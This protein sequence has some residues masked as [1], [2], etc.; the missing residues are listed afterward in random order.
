MQTGEIK[1]ANSYCTYYQP[2][3]NQRENTNIILLINDNT[4]GLCNDEDMLST[5]AMKMLKTV[6]ITI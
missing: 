3:W 6:Y 4:M 5:K 2:N 1:S